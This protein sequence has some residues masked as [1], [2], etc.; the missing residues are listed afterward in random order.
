MS[1]APP[2]GFLSVLAIFAM[3]SLLPYAVLPQQEIAGLRHSSMAPVLASVVGDSG[4]VFI[5]VGVVVSVLGAYLAWTLMAAEVL[6]IPATQSD[7]PRFL[8][9]ENKAKAF[10]LSSSFVQV[11]LVVILLAD[12]ALNFMLDLCTSLSLIPYFL[13][14]AYLLK[15][16][17][18]RET[19]EA[20]DRARTKE[21]V[22]GIVAVIYT[23]SSQ[24]P[25]S[26][27][28]LASSSPPAPCC[29]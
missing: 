28:S 24:G 20:G 27:C 29:T 4:A 13:S 6:Y 11:M 10:I 12:D 22:I 23:L 19:Y 7:M 17:I 2:F 3:V 16:A 5:S 1:A 25:S 21:L 18:T 9:R 15:I 26:C 8:K 14:A